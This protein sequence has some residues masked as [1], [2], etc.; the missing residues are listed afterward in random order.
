[1]RFWIVTKESGSIFAAPEDTNYFVLLLN[2]LI[3]DINQRRFMARIACNEHT[4]SSKAQEYL[5]L[6]EKEIDR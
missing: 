3:K 5:D 6:F 2:Q 4:W 1:M